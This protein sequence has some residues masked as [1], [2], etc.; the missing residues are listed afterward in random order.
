MR[1]AWRHVHCPGDRPLFKGGSPHLHSKRHEQSLH[2]RAPRFP[3]SGAGAGSHTSCGLTRNGRKPNQCTR[4]RKPPHGYRCSPILV[5]TS[6]RKGGPLCRRHAT[7]PRLCTLSASSHLVGQR[8]GPGPHVMQPTQRLLHARKPHRHSRQC[9]VF[10]T[11]EPVPRLETTLH[12][13]QLCQSG[14][15]ITGRSAARGG[16]TVDM[17]KSG[18]AVIAAADEQKQRSNRPQARVPS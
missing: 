17:A 18:P 14:T 9:R 15:T 12:M 6:V 10:S 1:G 16:A 13:T 8:E 4:S 5:E 11:A 3:P 2:R 7:A